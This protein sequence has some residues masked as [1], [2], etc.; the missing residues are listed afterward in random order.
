MA[1]E[2]TTEQALQSEARL[3]ESAV[4]EWLVAP[5]FLHRR[6]A[7][8]MLLEVAAE[9]LRRREQ[10]EAAEQIL[11][12]ANEIEVRATAGILTITQSTAA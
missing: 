6:T 5:D 1:T 11:S 8:T 12:I 3:A 7:E 9:I 10:P 2:V 4:Q